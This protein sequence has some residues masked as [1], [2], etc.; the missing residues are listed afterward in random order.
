MPESLDVTEIVP[1]DDDIGAAL[2]RLSTWDG[3]ASSNRLRGLLAYLVQE[4]L[5]GRGAM[6]R[7]KTIGLDHYGYSVEQLAD[8][9]SVVRVDLG[10]LRRRLGDYYRGD[11]AADPVRIILPKGSY[12]PEFAYVDPAGKRDAE[13]REGRS[14]AVPITA[15]SAAV[16]GIVAIAL[17][18]TWFLRGQDDAEG[19]TDRRRDAA[20]RTAVFDAS[21][22]RLQA[23]NLAE[24]GRDLIFPAVDPAR[25]RAALVTFEAAIEADP[26]YF[27][28]HAGAAQ[29][30]ATRALV[31]GGAD[32][33]AA[34]TENA[35][36]AL[37]LAPDEAWSQ[38][39]KAW[40]EFASGNHD[41][42]LVQSALALE[43]APDDLH[44]VEFE[45][46]ISLFSGEFDRVI[47]E[48]NRILGTLNPGDTGFVF[49]NALGSARYHSGDYEGAIAAFEES[50]ARGGPIG[51]VSMAYL[52]AAHHRLGQTERSRELAQQ[53]RNSW[54]NQRVDLLFER[55]FADPD[56]ADEL[57]EA[58]RGAGWSP[59]EDAG[60]G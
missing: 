36:R 41:D 16:L 59:V 28:G 51:P 31:L 13:P 6:I 42:A 19:V 9:E 57:A 5:A 50:V 35:D 4:T 30:H 24:S 45:S 3:L 25:L 27:G 44:I 60:R 14:R 7:G 38:S 22:L 17:V 40:T 15:V 29:V 33:L 47:R 2:E 46:L 52:M 23:I 8:R 21:P 54:P 20:Q 58:M 39:A 10:R 18:S 26:T 53:Y 12:A 37:V 32:D 48:T 1:S 43:L 11:G 34:A 56:H 49:T 55:L